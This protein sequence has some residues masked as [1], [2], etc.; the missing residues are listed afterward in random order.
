MKNKGFSANLYW[1]MPA[2]MFVTAE[3]VMGNLEYIRP[4]CVVL[5]LIIYYLLYLGV[6][7]VF[8]TTK[9][10]WPILNTVI[11]LL[12]V[13]EYFVISF[14]ERPAMFWDL[15]AIRT[16]MTVSANYNFVI[17]PTLAAMFAAVIGLSIWA[18]KCPKVPEV[19]SSWFKGFVLWGMSSL[20]FLSVLFTGIA[21]KFHLDVPMWDPVISFEKE[22]VVLSTVLSFKSVIAPK[23]EE[24]SVEEALM[25]KAGIQEEEPFSGRSPENVICIMN[26][27]FSDLRLLNGLAED[28]YFETDGEFL[29]FYDSL[30][31]AANTQKGN[32]YV[33]VFGAMT[34][35]S[36]YEFL[37]GNSCA[38]VP[39]GCIPYQFYTK[40]GDLSLAKV[41]R[42]QGYETIAMH[43]YPGYN[44]NRIEAYENLGFNQFSTHERTAPS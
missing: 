25:L 15:L 40:A 37:T 24:Y 34:A 13:M 39:Q 5:N 36:E 32:L 20:V 9:Y 38:F 44:W 14:R 8:R 33:P 43:P 17:T 23:P 3:T 2:L 21:P 42:E 19:R 41:F 27:S 12:A 26:E 18:W 4:F 31:D 16:A 29:E 6:Y 22:G 35:N 1:L 28:H 10:G 7:A 11:L 30:S